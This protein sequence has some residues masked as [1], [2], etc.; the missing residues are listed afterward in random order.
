MSKPAI[1]SIRLK[2][3]YDE[4]ARSDGQRILVDGMW[5]RGVSKAELEI[6]EWMKDLAPS[7]ELRQWFGH[8]PQRWDGFLERYRRELEDNE[9]R[10]GELLAHCAEGRV[11]LVYAASDT[12]HNNAVALKRH[13]ESLAE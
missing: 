4:P 5:P 12:E 11:T 13:L 1:H 10:V 6:D 2:R 3:A 7:R 9:E 8:D